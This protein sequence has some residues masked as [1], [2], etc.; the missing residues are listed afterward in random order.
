MFFGCF[1]QK[2]SLLRMNK[3][4]I[5]ILLGVVLLI[6]SLIVPPIVVPL[7]NQKKRDKRNADL[8]SDSMHDGREV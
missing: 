4:D 6:L 5:I 7:M 8:L 2:G 1:S 3:D